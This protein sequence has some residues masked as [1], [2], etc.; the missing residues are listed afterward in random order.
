MMEINQPSIEDRI[1]LLEEALRHVRDSMEEP[2]AA[3]HMEV[4][5]RTFRDLLAG[6]QARLPKGLE[7]PPCWATRQ[8]AKEFMAEGDRVYKRLPEMVYV[9][10]PIMAV[11]VHFML[12]DL[13]TG[14]ASPYT[15]ALSQRM[16]YLL[17]TLQSDSFDGTQN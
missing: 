1:R 11:A 3:A 12:E 8:L 7:T 9:W 6:V 15:D 17:L 13:V 2:Q 10:L 4:L 14:H 5:S 16:R